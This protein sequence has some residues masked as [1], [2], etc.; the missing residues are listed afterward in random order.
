MVKKLAG[1]PNL[2]KP[3][4]FT[5]DGVDSLCQVNEVDK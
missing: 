2:E 5:I 1:H 3:E 4:G